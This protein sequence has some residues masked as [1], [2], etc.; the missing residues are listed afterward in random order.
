MKQFL[1]KRWHRIPVSIVMATL[2]VCLLAGSAFA[3]YGFFHATMNVEVQEAIYPSYGWDDDLAPYMANLDG[4]PSGGVLPLVTCI[5]DKFRAST[6]F[7]VVCTIAEKPGVDASELVAGEALVLPINLR[8]R[9]DAPLTV[10]TSYTGAANGVTLEYAWETNDS[11][12]TYK[13]NGP[14]A[15]L[16]SFSVVLPAHGGSFGSAYVGATVLFVK[17]TVANDA[18]P[19][20]YTFVITFNRN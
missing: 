11:G 10:T 5:P 16:G 17:V 15:D 7:S 2:V 6:G 3:I 12:A 19:G 9:S 20:P 14:W 18:V 1:K 8:N 13:S 4:T